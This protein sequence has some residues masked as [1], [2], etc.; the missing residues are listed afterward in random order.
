M[1]ET[2]E[3]FV[4]IACLIGMSLCVFGQYPPYYTVCKNTILIIVSICLPI[5]LIKILLVIVD[6]VFE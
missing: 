1:S 5:V 4:G 6:I 3:W 2:L